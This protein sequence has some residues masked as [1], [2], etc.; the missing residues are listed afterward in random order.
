[1]PTHCRVVEVGRMWCSE[2]TTRLMAV[3]VPGMCEYL[4]LCDAII[5]LLSSGKD[6]TSSTTLFSV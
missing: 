2:G 5:R 1:M 6:D 4:G 3:D